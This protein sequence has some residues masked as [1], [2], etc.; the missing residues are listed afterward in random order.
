[1]NLPRTQESL[2]QTTLSLSIEDLKKPLDRIIQIQ[3]T[4]SEKDSS[5]R[6]VYSSKAAS[7]VILLNAQKL[8]K[9]IEDILEQERDK[10]K[11]EKEPLVL[12]I[13]QEQHFTGS[14]KENLS[15]VDKRWLKDIELIFEENISSPIRLSEVAYKVA[16][17]ERQ[18][19]RRI[20]KLIGL[21]P[22]HYLRLL[23]LY[24]AHELLKERRFNTIAEV[25][26]QVGFRDA[27]YFVKKYKDIYNYSPLDYIR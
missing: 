26:Q 6:T 15:Q 1:M 17:S 7:E 13:A 5:E 9:L 8:A 18:L 12:R 25:A 19:H 27:H 16:V 20:N 23:R 10:L 22:N 4:Y 24:R 3:E 11:K 14:I 2:T 21:T